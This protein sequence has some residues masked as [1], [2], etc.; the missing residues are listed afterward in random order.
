MKKS[1][2]VLLAAVGTAVM[3]APAVGAD[4]PEL[5]VGWTIPAEEAKYLMMK[6]PE[7]F[8]DLG[9]KY[10]IKWTQF[11]GTSPMVQA[12]RAKVLD[13]ATMAPLSLAQGFLQSGL[14]TYIVAQH[15][16]EKPGYFSVYWAVKE[17][18]P[19][20]KAED[21]KGKVLGTNAYGS[22]VYY[23]LVL[24]LKQ[25]G[26][27][28]VNDV[29]IVETGFPAAADAIRSGRVDMATMVQPF[30]LLADEKG[31]LRTIGSQAEVLSPMVQIFEGCTQEYTDANPEVVKLYLKDLESAMQ[32]VIADPKLA[33]AVTSEITR[34]PADLLGKFLMTNK[35]FARDEDMKPNLEAIQKQ[36]VQYHE[37]G[38][39]NK[40]LDVNDFVRKDVM[41][42]SQ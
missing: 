40:Q 1:L 9:K 27:D 7:L 23:N 24:W 4:I 31:G 18:S 42:G 41:A 12:M 5:R 32:K 37:A 20:Q 19:I 30:G 6:R 14:K 21:L 28:P 33:V 26:I 34:A 38:F 16:Y 22:G 8:P 39:L 3:A 36:F 29:K 2:K 35:D 10:T 25:H 13:C 17:D 15:V 11:Q